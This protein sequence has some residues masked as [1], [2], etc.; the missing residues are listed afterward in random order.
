MCVGALIC[1]LGG[2]SPHKQVVKATTAQFIF[3]SC[4]QFAIFSVELFSKTKIIIYKKI[5]SIL[6]LNCCLEY[7]T[8]VTLTV[9][10]A[11]KN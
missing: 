8:L 5:D 6:N 9:N 7:D 1:V 3:V 10:P 11:T 2:P 4:F